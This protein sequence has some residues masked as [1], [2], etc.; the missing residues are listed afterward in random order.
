MYKRQR[1]YIIVHV[2]YQKEEEYKKGHIKGAIYIDTNELES[3]PLWNVVSDEKIK[4]LLSATGIT[5]DKMIIIYSDEPMASGRL[6]HVLMYAGV[7]DVRIINSNIKG[8]ITAGLTL[9]QGSNEWV[10]DDDFGGNIP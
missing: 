6:A 3:L 9:E 2:D 1:E 7:E 10:P 8:L 5:K 4:N